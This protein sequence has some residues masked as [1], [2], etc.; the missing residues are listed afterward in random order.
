MDVASEEPDASGYGHHGGRTRGL[1]GLLK[2][3]FAGGAAWTKVATDSSANGLIK[4]VVADFSTSEGRSAARDG[5]KADFAGGKPADMK[6]KS[7][8]ELRQ[9]SA[10]LK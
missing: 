1:W 3:A 10:L 6:T 4:S 9:V 8:E 5:L 7:V 2:E